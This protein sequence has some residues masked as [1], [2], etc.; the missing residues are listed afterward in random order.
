MS[1][2]DIFR[3]KPKQPDDQIKSWTYTD[4]GM[5]NKGWDL[6]WWQQDLKPPRPGTNETVEACIS[7][8]SQTVAMCPIEHLV[9]QENGETIRRVGSNAERAL[10]NPNAYT[11]RSLFFNELIRL[12]VFPWQRVCRGDP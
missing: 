1:L 2:L 3:R 8:L 5:L 4:E 11:T 12:H 7:A 9:V 10:L 6:G